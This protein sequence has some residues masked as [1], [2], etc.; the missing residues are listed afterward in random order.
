MTLT[1]GTGPFGQHPAGRFDFEP[2]DHVVYVERFPRRVRAMRGGST[3]IDS[4][5]V[6]LVYESG[7]LPSYAFPPDD[8]WVEA[9]ASDPA[10]AGYVRVPWDAVDA[11]FEEDEEVFVHVRDPYHRIDVVPTSRHVVVSF[12]DTVLAESTRVRGLYETA[13][14][15]RWYFPVEDVRTELLVRSDTLTSCAYKGSPAHWSARLPGGLVDD[16]GWSYEG[17]V[18]RE[19]EDVEGRIAFYNERVDIRV[20]GTLQAR[21]DTPWSR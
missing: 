7:Q 1:V 5:R 9:A 16:V 14:P 3:V 20:D 13:L 8:V 18:R 15:V 21:P 11:W 19:A 4:D 17:P 12:N 2:P 10:V 6:V